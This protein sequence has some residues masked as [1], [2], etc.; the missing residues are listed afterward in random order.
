M[1]LAVVTS[2]KAFSV[3]DTELLCQDISLF[4]LLM[5]SGDVVRGSLDVGGLWINRPQTPTA[6]VPN[7]LGAV[8][9]WLALGYGETSTSTISC[10]SI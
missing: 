9:L 3:G 5:Q 6:A 4:D 8:F 1:L 2:A 7:K 10:D